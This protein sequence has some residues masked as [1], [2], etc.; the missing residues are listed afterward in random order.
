MKLVIVML[1]LS[2]NTYALDIDKYVDILKVKVQ[3]LLGQKEEEVPKYQLPNIPIVKLDATSLDVYNKKG[4]IHTQG[5]SFN[6]L[7]NPDKRKFRMAFLRELYP[8][9]RGVIAKTEEL[10]LGINML[11]QGGTR[12]GVYRSLVLS[13]DYRTL[14]QY[15]ESPSVELISFGLGYGEKYL[16]LAF[17]KVQMEQLNLW[18]IKSVIVEKTLEI[19]DAFPKD[20]KDLYKWYAILSHELNVKFSGVWKNKS[21][22]TKSMEYHYKWASQ[23]PF[24]HIKSEVI[25]KLHKAMNSFR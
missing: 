8:S 17:D 12:E 4:K 19:L 14:V 3:K 18:G 9:V 6:K 24:Q 7:S 5:N 16:A 2:S 23:V 1:I 13:N 21:R 11:E 22:R 25:V 20:G 10:V 15:E